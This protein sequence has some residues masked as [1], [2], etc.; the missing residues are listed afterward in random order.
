LTQQA[1]RKRPTLKRD[2]SYVPGAEPELSGFQDGLLHF[3][4][5]LDEHE[6]VGGV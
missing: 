4:G 1:W 6:V 5:Q 3:A 2:V